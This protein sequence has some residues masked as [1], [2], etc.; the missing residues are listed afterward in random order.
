[1]ILS[2]VQF[3]FP[4]FENFYIFFNNVLKKIIFKLTIKMHSSGKI[5]CL[6]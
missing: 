4:E 6:R 1:M 3:I 5:K 2:E